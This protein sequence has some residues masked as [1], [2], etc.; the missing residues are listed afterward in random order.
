MGGQKGEGRRRVFC[1]RGGCVVLSWE[2]MVEVEV[3]VE[4]MNEMG[5][6]GTLGGGMRQL[7]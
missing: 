6:D 1:G 4:V 7:D 5:W 2:S 3:E